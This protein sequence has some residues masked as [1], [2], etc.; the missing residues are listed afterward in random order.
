MAR[1]VATKIWLVGDNL[2]PPLM[3]PTLYGLAA[4]DSAYGQIASGLAPDPAIA[5]GRLPVVNPTQLAA[6]IA[7]IRTYENA[8]PPPDRQAILMA[9]FPGAAGDFAADVMEVAAALAGSYTNRLILPDT[10][11]AMRSLLLSNL[12]AGAARLQLPG[13]GGYESESAVVTVVGGGHGDRAFR[14]VRVRRPGAD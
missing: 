12:N 8:P 1:V 14:A 2:V 7:R 4:S 10:T 5:V 11:T 6:L 3:V 9:D 13:S